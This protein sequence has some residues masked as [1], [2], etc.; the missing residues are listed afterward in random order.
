MSFISAKE[1][2]VKWGISQ[3]RV[4][5]LCAEKRIHNA[6]MVGNVWISPAD[7]EKP[8]DAHTYPPGHNQNND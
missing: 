1:A 4:S 2:A 6:E 7:A 5:T 3:R 8:Q